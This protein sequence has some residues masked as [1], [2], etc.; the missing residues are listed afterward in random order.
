M[1]APFRLAQRAFCAS[2]ILFLAAADI[3][4]APRFPVAL[5]RFAVRPLFD[6]ALEV[7]ADG[8]S[9]PGKVCDAARVAT[10]N[11]RCGFA[12]VRTGGSGLFRGG[13]QGD[14]AFNARYMMELFITADN[15]FNRVN[16]GGYSGNQLSPYFGHPTMAQ[17]PRQ[18]QVGMQFR[19]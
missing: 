8:D 7:S 2:E 10:V 6:T 15:L 18:V 9:L 12:T 4:R 5:A 13:N 14:A 16:Y 19:F 17:R 11:P 3:F 1:A